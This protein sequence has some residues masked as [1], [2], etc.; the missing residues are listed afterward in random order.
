MSERE[1]ND[2]SIPGE[3]DPGPPNGTNASSTR[4]DGPAVIYPL[5]SSSG[6][7]R[8][9]NDWLTG[10]EAYTVYDGDRPVTE[11]EF[12]LCIVDE[13]GLRRHEGDIAAARSAAQPV[14]LPVLL[15]CSGEQSAFVE[16][17][18]GGA[19][20]TVDEIVSLPIRQAELKWRIRTLLRLRNQS[21]GLQRRTDEL[22]QFREAAEASGHAIYITDAEGTIEY[23]NPAFEGITGYSYDEV[24][25]E[26]PSLLQSGA[27]D[28]DLY[29]E[30]WE[31]I[32]DGRQWH[33]EMIDESNEGER[34][35]LEQTISPVVTEGGTVEKFVAVAQ[36][37]T[38][39]K[40]YEER[41]E[42][43]R[44]DL[45]L[46]NQVV[47]HDIRNDLQ[48]VK[49]YTEMLKESV[50]SEARSDL[51]TVREAVENAI[52]LTGS[53][54]D[55]ADVMLQSSTENTKIDIGSTLRQ[56]VRETQ[57]E[58]T[59]AVIDIEEPLPGVTVTADQMLS[60]VFRNLLNNAIQHND[61]D[62]PRVTVS[63]ER[64]DEAVTV[65]VADNGPGVPDAQKDEIFGKGEKGLD[66]AGTGIGLYLVQ[67]LVES[68][69][70]EARIEDN[71][72]TGAVF[73]VTL[74]VAE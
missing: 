68:Y 42:T 50:A 31:T 14:L 23:V 64:S 52:T 24:V 65:R 32:L 53:A 1:R 57:T 36:D 51:E 16:P 30:L 3:I 29:E 28:G 19:F 7:E 4:D 38:E 48:L 71:D 56:Q 10:E 44:D 25:G 66:S 12:D 70:G 67:S 41:L 27:Y 2:S 37:V 63:A 74:P 62:T 39:R 49:G 11:A 59:N 54:R 47:R 8:V 22:R 18:G 35:V 55:L 43:Q 58:H 6:N 33:R 20:E 34:I 61:K 60:S 69:G 13:P 73:S 26:K 5:L 46:L 40:R 21:L 9:L 45:E 72:P 17:G 15:L